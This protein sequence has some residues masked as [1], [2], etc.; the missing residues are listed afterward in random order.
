MGGRG[1]RRHSRRLLRIRRTSENSGQPIYNGIGMFK[2]NVP[3]A[4]VVALDPN[5][6]L[7]KLL[8]PIEHKLL[9]PI[10]HKLLIPIEHKLLIPIEHKLLI[11]IEHKLL[12][13]IEHKL[14]IPIEHK[15]LIPIE[16]KL[17]IPIEH[18]LLIPIEHK[19]LIPI[20][21][22]LLIPIEHK[23]LIPIEHKLLIPIEHKLLIPIEHK[24]LIP[25][26]H[27]LLIPIEHKLLIP[28]E[29]K[30][31]LLLQNINM[32]QDLRSCSRDP[33][34]K[35]LQAKKDLETAISAVV[36]AEQQ[37][38]DNGR[39][40]KAQINSCISRHLECLRSREV[41][42]MEQADLIQQLKEE[43]L[44]Q[45]AQQ[46]YR[47]LG[48][49]NCLIHQLETPHSNDLANQIS[50]CLER[51]GSLTLKPEESST[52]DFEAD[53]S[54]L[55]QV[56]TTFGSIK[57]M[58]FE[59]EK[60]AP[61][62]NVP[63]HFVS[64]NP[65]LLSKCVVPASEQQSLFGTLDCPLSKW[66]KKETNL[67]PCPDL[68]IPSFPIQDWLPKKQFKESE[69]L[70]TSKPHIFSM[71]QIW[72]QLGELHNWLLQPKQNEDCPEEMPCVRSRVSSFSNSSIENVESEDCDL[73][74][75]EEMD[76]SD[77][78]I[79]PVETEEQTDQ[80]DKWKLIFKPFFEDYT[81]SDWLPKVESCG[82]CC[83]GQ[84]AALEIENL[85]KLK[86]LNEQLGAKK[87]SVSS[88]DMW[89]LQRA[90]PALR[91][92]DVCKANELCS[93][94]SECVC[95][96]S[97]EKAVF[98]KWLL[99]KEGK[100]KNGIPL[101]QEHKPQNHEPEKSKP[102]IDMWLRPCK[103]DLEDKCKNN[104]ECDPCLRKF[105]ALLETPLTTWVAKP[106]RADEKASKETT[107]SKWKVSSEGTLPSFHLPHKSGNWVLPSKNTDNSEKTEQPAVE[108]KWLL[109]KKAH[110][111]YALPGVCDL[112]ACMKLAADKEKWLYRSPLQVWFGLQVT[113]Y[114]SDGQLLAYYVA[115]LGHRRKAGK[116][117]PYHHSKI[118]LCQNAR[119]ALIT[120][121]NF[122]FNDV[123]LQL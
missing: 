113:F 123:N 94:F 119:N 104:D 121:N 65:W 45:Q 89:L 39:E 87:A 53:V 83:G 85:G 37:V 6:D 76:M 25:I 69:D 102:S 16:H 44:Q 67:S 80:V 118:L 111:Y 31:S 75:E 101:K 14:L 91:V 34:S 51:L 100:D 98:N 42:L 21:H 36:K 114:G 11:P 112:F 116:Q 115:L 17:L 52:L 78:L 57:T 55:R 38:K 88:N 92:E 99:N 117:A 7:H 120:V 77:W 8:I 47:L 15:L 54:S 61:I 56:I 3:G 48:Q 41:W 86:C 62:N 1:C 105:R 107:E 35:C 66:L 71:E 20:E 60:P 9:I 40:V 50:V 10:E 73:Q 59:Q 82:S 32:E 97:C 28:I 103:R 27:K 95:D 93:S 64:E 2:F 74:D 24:L 18:K 68:N 63:C 12:I 90:Q 22:K 70:S 23:L 4:A 33:L 108:D 46:L 30:H 72:G 13:P 26:E 84:K 49:F 79:S 109:R 58:N 81:M 19:F 96:E 110:D 5:D 106:N 29:H 43:A 122:L